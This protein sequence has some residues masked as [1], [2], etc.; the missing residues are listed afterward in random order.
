MS[1]DDVL[2][3]SHAR[4]PMP[5]GELERLG[6]RRWVLE[7]LPKGGIGAEIGVFRGHFSNLICEIAQPKKLYLVDPWTTLGETFGWGKAYTNFDTLPTLVA[8][9]DARAH[10]QRHPGI[11]CVI[12][13]S[14]YPACA[15]QIVEPLDFAYLDASHKYAP[16][17]AELRS[18]QK[19]LK[20]EGLIIGDDWDPR[21]DAPHH[22]VWRAIQDFIAESDWRLI[23]A[24]P[25]RQWALTRMPERQA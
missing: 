4:W 24:G 3:E 8:R 7:L 12:V 16:T 1:P 5:D 11:D 15:S 2:R 23:K 10:V 22:G 9:E 25:G 13:E 17:L 19:Q 6:K 20:P 21:P 14:T 18:I